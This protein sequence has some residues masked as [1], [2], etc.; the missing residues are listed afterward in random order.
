[1]P[2]LSPIEEN[3]KNQEL[4]DLIQQYNLTSHDNKG[5][6]KALL[7]EMVPFIKGESLKKMDHWLSDFKNHLNFYEINSKLISP[8][9]HYKEA[10]QQQNQESEPLSSPKLSS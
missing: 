9:N 5:K 10:L 6:R 3:D 7:L 8:V 4:N 1:M 2:I